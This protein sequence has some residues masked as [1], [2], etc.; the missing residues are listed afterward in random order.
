MA[1][2]L[3]IARLRLRHRILM[4]RDDTVVALPTVMGDVDNASGVGGIDDDHGSCID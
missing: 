3:R 1:V 4:N 2:E